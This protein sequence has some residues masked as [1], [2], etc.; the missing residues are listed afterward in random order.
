MAVHHN[1]EPI[2]LDCTAKLA[3]KFEIAK[4]NR[5]IFTNNATFFLSFLIINPISLLIQNECL[6][7]K[8]TKTFGK[9][10]G[11]GRKKFRPHC[12]NA[13]ETQLRQK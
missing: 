7:R 1:R 3:I 9:N 12:R 6:C 11:F 2:G 13:D 10:K 5:T 4:I 8:V